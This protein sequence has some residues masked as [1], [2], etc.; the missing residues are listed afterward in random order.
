MVL[1]HSFH[2]PPP[3]TTPIIRHPQCLRRHRRRGVDRLGLQVLRMIR[4]R[5]INQGRPL[6]STRLKGRIQHLLHSLHRAMLKVNKGT[7]IKPN[8]R[9][10]LGE[11][12]AEGQHQG[13]LHPER[14]LLLERTTARPLKLPQTHRNQLR[15]TKVPPSRVSLHTQTN[16]PSHNRIRPRNRSLQRQPIRTRKHPDNKRRGERVTEQ[17]HPNLWC[18]PPSS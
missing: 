17:R 11:A 7:Q 10:R 13:D 12:K 14:T 4:T 2:P 8:R 16:A 18:K 9:T 15:G 6:P 5:R 1:L 3:P